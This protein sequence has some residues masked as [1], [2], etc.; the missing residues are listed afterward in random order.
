MPLMLTKSKINSENR[1]K[2]FAV[3][4]GI[5]QLALV[6]GI[7]LGRLDNPHPSLD[8]ISGMLMGFSLVGNLAY[9]V[10]L[11][12]KWSKHDRQKTY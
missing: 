4:G 12:R 2:Y 3:L 5:S 1:A 10:V 8:F 11:S 7:F 9:L 6:L